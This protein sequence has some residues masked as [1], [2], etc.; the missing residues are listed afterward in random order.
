MRKAVYSLLPAAVIVVF[1]LSLGSCKYLSFLNPGWGL[2]GSWE[3]TDHPDTP[4]YDAFAYYVFRSGA[5]G[6]Q[7]QDADRTVWQS[8]PILNLTDSSY[9]YQIEENTLYPQ[10]E[11]AENYAEYTLDGDDLTIVL[12]TDR[13]KTAQIATLVCVRE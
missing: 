3:I 13:D 7:I 12:Y 5:E 6:F 8:G 10:F 9:D 1:A 4:A 2:Q 11:G